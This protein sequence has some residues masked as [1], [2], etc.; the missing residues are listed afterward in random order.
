MYIST[1]TCQNVYVLKNYMIQHGQIQLHHPIKSSNKSVEILHQ[2][3]Q[4]LSY[5][6]I[7]A[8]Q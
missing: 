8:F 3:Y 5:I 2:F 4:I 7:V 6:K 1:G